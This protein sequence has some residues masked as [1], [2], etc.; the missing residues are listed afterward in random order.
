MQL[1]LQSRPFGFSFFKFPSKGSNLKLGRVQRLAECVKL[2][3]PC[4]DS[5]FQPD[6]FGLSFTKFMFEGRVT[7]L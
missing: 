4:F 5:P 3:L 1:F 7:L 2:V 6:T